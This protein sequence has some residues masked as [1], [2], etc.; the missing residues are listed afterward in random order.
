MKKKVKENILNVL[1]DVKKELLVQYH[2][3]NVFY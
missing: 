1:V 2:N 3:S